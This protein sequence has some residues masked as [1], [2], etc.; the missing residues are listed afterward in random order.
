VHYA[1]LV[2]AAR[3]QGGALRESAVQ[4][5][6]DLPIATCP[7]WRMY[8]LVAHLGGVHATILQAVAGESPKFERPSGSWTDVLERWDHVFAALLGRLTDGDPALR[9]W[10]R[11]T[12]HETAIHRLDAD[13][14]V[15]DLPTLVYDTEFAADGIDEFLGLLPARPSPVAGT[16][17]Y[18]A[19]DAGRAWQVR[20]EVG[21][22]PVTTEPSGSGVD[23]DVSVVG[24][25]DAVYRS[26]WGRP[27]TA[28]VTGD[29]SILA[30]VAAP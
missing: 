28:V 3:V 14:A 18:H 27:S 25:A 22:P 23:F 10:A 8:D 7:G 9:P 21:Q 19:A 6:P 20:L 12:A 4:A 16:L 13:S 2:E 17:L 29:R 30:A 15:K 5:G 24:T 26:V 11:R 1:E